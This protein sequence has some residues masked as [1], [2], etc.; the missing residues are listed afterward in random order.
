MKV[1]N[2]FQVVYLFAAGNEINYKAVI[3]KIGLYTPMFVLEI[4][5][6]K[7]QFQYYP[8]INVLIFQEVF[9]FQFS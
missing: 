1:I 8:P 6:F 4:Q 7:D 2:V 9:S 3:Y 5:F